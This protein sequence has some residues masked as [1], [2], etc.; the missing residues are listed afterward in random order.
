MP[1][2]RDLVSNVCLKS[3]TTALEAHSLYQAAVQ[4][5]AAI[6]AADLPSLEK[7]AFAD[8][9]AAEKKVSE[10]QCCCRV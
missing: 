7:Q 3:P 8:L 9:K 6:L 4:A 2:V 1:S 10:W 5:L